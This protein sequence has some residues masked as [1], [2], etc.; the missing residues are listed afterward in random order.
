MSALV[1]RIP[2]R[3]GESVAV[4]DRSFDRS[5]A[6]GFGG[7]VVVLPGGTAAGM[8]SVRG[9]VI[10]AVVSAT[11]RGPVSGVRLAKKYHRMSARTISPIS[12]GQMERPSFRWIGMSAMGHR[13]GCWQ[14]G[15]ERAC[16][17]AAP[18]FR[19]CRA[20]DDHEWLSWLGTSGE[21]SQSVTF[22]GRWSA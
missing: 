6:Q 10:V 2:I 22:F 19:G 16:S 13:P 11:P 12:H 21:W 3:S 14:R 4:A 17:G 7:R 15:A 8:V 18:H 1:I 5:T 20:G 9:V